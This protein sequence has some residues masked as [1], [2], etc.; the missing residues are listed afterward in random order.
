M[1]AMVTWSWSSVSERSTAN[2]SD[3]CDEPSISATPPSTTTRRA[4][5]IVSSTSVKP[6]SAALVLRQRDRVRCIGFVSRLVVGDHVVTDGVQALLEGDVARRRRRDLPEDGPIDTV[7]AAVDAVAPE[8]RIGRD[9]PRERDRAVAAG[10]R[11][12]ACG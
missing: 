6:A 2:D 10:A 4:T 11:D 7:G 12:S 1:R 9:A 5:V 8:V 3:R